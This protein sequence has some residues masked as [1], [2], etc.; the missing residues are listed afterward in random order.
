MA[1][2]DHECDGT[3]IAIAADGR[4]YC[5]HCGWNDPQ[6]LESAPPSSSAVRAS[7]EPPVVGY[8]APITSAPYCLACIEKHR[9]WKPQDVAPVYD[10]HETCIQCGKSLRASASPSD[11]GAA[12]PQPAQEDD[13]AP[14][15]GQCGVP[16]MDNA[17]IRCADCL[18]AALSSPSVADSPTW[19]PIETAPKNGICVLL[20]GEN[21][22]VLFGFWRESTRR[23]TQDGSGHTVHG[24]KLWMS[25]PASPAAASQKESPRGN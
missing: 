22:V 9:P 3:N 14:E 18:A 12:R 15:C 8:R 5:A 21:N 10:T 24:A 6:P 4:I 16:V 19:Q 13:P 2:N 17:D 1:D 11:D 20:T 25:L 23:W 7:G